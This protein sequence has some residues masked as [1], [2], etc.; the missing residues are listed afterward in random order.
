MGNALVTTVIQNLTGDSIIQD[1]KYNVL[2]WAYGV[3][4]GG[5]VGDAVD[6]AVGDAVRDA[7]DG[8]V[9]GAVWEVIRRAYGHYLGGQF[10]VHD[11]GCGRS[12][13]RWCGRL[14]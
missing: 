13:G 4:D 1:G 7:V 12:C 2:V 11:R 6:G 9:R 3:V 14:S 10:W 8:A 5:A